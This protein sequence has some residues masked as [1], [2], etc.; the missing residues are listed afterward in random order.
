MK[1]VFE[2]ATYAEILSDIAE[3]LAS[4]PVQ[5]V[6]AKNIYGGVSEKGSPE[7]D[8]VKP[9]AGPEP[10]PQG[11]DPFGEEE[12]PKNTPKKPKAEP[13]KPKAEPKKSKVKPVEKPV[14]EPVEE[15]AA[16]EEEP[17]EEDVVLSPAE[18]AAIKARTVEDLQAAFSAG[19][20]KQV[21]AILAKY[22]DGAKTF[23]ELSTDAFIPI[24]KAIDAG[25][26]A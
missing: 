9:V 20:Q 19:K 5:E 15:P 25:E 18:I 4:A 11:P 1:L 24:R 6:P 8:T 10:S 13:K 12:P 22:G 3:V 16:E 26:L 17:A 2:R 23:R 21:F 7:R 14:D